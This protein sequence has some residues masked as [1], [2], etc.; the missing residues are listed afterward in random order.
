M[1]D[2]HA[3]PAVEVRGLHKRFGRQVALA[4]VDLT[5]HAGQVTGF[6]GA[7][8]AGK[9]TTL[10]I[11]TGLASADAARRTCSASRTGGTRTRPAWPAP[12]SR[13]AP[14]IPP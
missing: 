9:S 5:A 6:L 14:S 8:G 1:H 12:C 11:L 3:T 13:A 2:D 10:R 4:G 7:N